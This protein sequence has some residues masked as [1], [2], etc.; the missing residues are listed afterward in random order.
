MDKETIYQVD[1]LL[2]EQGLYGPLELLLAEGRLGYGDYRGWRSGEPTYLE[3]CLFGDPQ[4]VAQQLREAAAYATARRLVAEVVEYRNWS[5]EDAATLRFS[6]QGE[7]DR[8]FHKRFVRPENTAQLD[9]FLDN[10][11][12]MLAN[13]VSDALCNRDQ[14]AARAALEQLYQID[15]ANARLGA[16]D[17]LVSALETLP[18]QSDGPQLLEALEGDLIPLAEQTLGGQGRDYIAIFWEQLARLLEG[19]PFDPANP[20]L[21]LSYCAQRLG[22]WSW[23]LACLQGEPWETHGELVMRH[24]LASYRLRDEV[25]LLRDWW[26]LCALDSDQ[27]ARLASRLGSEWRSLWETFLDAE[28]PLEVRDFPAWLLIARPGLAARVPLSHTQLDGLPASLELLHSLRQLND[29]LGE[30]AMALRRRLQQQHPALFAC[31][32]AAPRLG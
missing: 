4:E 3:D 26:R 9:L 5:R 11:G 24:G 10:G 23:L 28:Q 16:L 14:E 17:H 22:D 12:S 7:R 29:P 2:A 21:H 27:A 19:Q 31:L 6:A 32:L 25:G 13:Q 8:L 30:A 1:K 15:A 18:T 20:R